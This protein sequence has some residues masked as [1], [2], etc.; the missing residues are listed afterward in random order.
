MRAKWTAWGSV[1][2]RLTLWFVVV[3]GTLLA[4]FSGF[5]YVLFER[6]LE[7]RLNQAL[8]ATATTE[9][10]FFRGELPE[11]GRD[12]LAA[13][14][15]IR[16]L[17][18]VDH[19]LAIYR[20]ETLLAGHI[21]EL[22]AAIE[23][24]GI[25]RQARER[26]GAVYLDLPNWRREEGGGRAVALWTGAGGGDH[27]LVAVTSRR[28]VIDPLATV[29]H[30]LW[31]AMPVALLLTAV[32]GF[33]LARK[34]LAPVERSYESI[35]RFTADASHEL[36]T[37]LAVV[38]GESDVALARERSAAEYRESL[39]TIRDEARRM[40]A[41]VDDMLSLA[42]IDAG[43]VAPQKQELY[44]NDLVEECARSTAALAQQ[45][46]VEFRLEPPE[47]IRFHGDERHLRRM[48]MSL[49]EN[50]VK[51]TP[52][53]GSVWARLEGSAGLVTFTVGDSGGGI[54]PEQAAHVFDRFYRLDEGRSRD[55][56]GFGLGLAVAK[57]VADAHQGAIRL[58]NHPGR[59]AVFTVS[60][61][62]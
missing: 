48:V 37:P 26:R 53:G 1:R 51:Y 33:L 49:L 62:R 50:A 35:R 42:R 59:G 10:V 23:Q 21:K 57:A 36:R 34:S 47:E 12:T 13:G 31:F 43:Q 29:R 41:L 54:P 18:P 22:G 30:T 15:V 7:E 28:N 24:S 14:E 17:Q 61:P 4:A 38:R 25:L 5:F 6:V 3:I 19:L 8:A 27:V 60:L 20:G 11:L 39:A 46:G 16:D 55:T 2:V 56:G 44:L 32:S 52:A 58:E 9:D 45:K 40:S